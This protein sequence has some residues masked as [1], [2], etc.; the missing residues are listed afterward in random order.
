MSRGVQSSGAPTV[1][2]TAENMAVMLSRMAED[3]DAQLRIGQGRYSKST[4]LQIVQESWQFVTWTFANI[5]PGSTEPMQAWAEWLQKY[6]TRENKQV[7]ILASVIEQ[8]LPVLDPGLCSSSSSATAMPKSTAI[9]VA[10]KAKQGA[11]KACDL[12]ATMPKASNPPANRATVEAT[13]EDEVTSDD[14]H[15]MEQVLKA[16]KIE[17]AARLLLSADLQELQFAA[18]HV[19][20]QMSPDAPETLNLLGM[21]ISTYCVRH[22]AEQ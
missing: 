13:V 12:P 7:R 22:A 11:P 2:A 17:K 14:E 20:L 6:M 10:P 4:Y 9:P 3:P 21:L 8:Q 19:S 18:R 1:P 15:A 16:M 5:G